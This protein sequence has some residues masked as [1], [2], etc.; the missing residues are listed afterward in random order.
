MRSLKIII[1][2]DTDKPYTMILSAPLLVGISFGVLALVSLLTFSVMSNVMLYAQASDGIT[3]T[4]SAPPAATDT[5]EDSGDNPEDPL[6]ESQS[7]EEIAEDQPATETPIPV[8]VEPQLTDYQPETGELEVT[9]M[10]AP[11]IGQSAI[12]IRALVNK[13]VNPGASAQGRFIAFLI[14]R[15]GNIGPSFPA[16]V[17]VSGDTY[18]GVESISS[19]RIGY[20][21]PYD[22]RFANINPDEFESIALCIFDYDSNLLTWRTIVP[23]Q[24]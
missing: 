2:R 19:F 16:G 6:L 15:D 22:V 12:S 8:E 13:R 7:G 5:P 4:S 23:L 9:A 3:S 24:R 20:R 14:D 17:S 1:F 11:V 21:R 18:Q 10:D